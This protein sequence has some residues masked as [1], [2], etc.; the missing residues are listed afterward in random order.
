[1][2]ERGVPKYV[3]D[4]SYYR[5]GYQTAAQ[6]LNAARS[7]L[8]KSAGA[9]PLDGQVRVE[10]ARVYEGLALETASRFIAEADRAL[11]AYG[12]RGGGRGWW[13]TGHRSS[14]DAREERLARFLR[15]TVKPCLTLVMAGAWAHRGQPQDVR[16]ADAEAEAVRLV[17]DLSYRAHYNLACFEATRATGDEARQ[18]RALADLRTALLRAPGP[19]RRA[20]L[21]RW[22]RDDP[23]L[24]TIRAAHEFTRL[25]S[26]YDPEGQEEEFEYTSTAQGTGDDQTE[27]QAGTTA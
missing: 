8:L 25:V 1:M 2:P 3:F 7:E 19:R 14:L 20:E 16:T 4:P 12:S 13:W 18:T 22:A 23:A 24:H 11:D 6:Q 21:A 15:R 17:P 9:E 27:G 5:L 26:L 10:A